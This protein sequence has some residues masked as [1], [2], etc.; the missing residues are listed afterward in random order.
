MK[1][2]EIHVKL[3][4]AHKKSYE[5]QIKSHEIHIRHSAS[6]EGV[7]SFSVALT[8]LFSVHLRDPRILATISF[9]SFAHPF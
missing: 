9:F 8:G 6:C 1:S 4:E 5:I 2:H 3:H 7:F